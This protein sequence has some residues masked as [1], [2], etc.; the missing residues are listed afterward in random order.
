[1]YDD[2]AYSLLVEIVVKK[3]NLDPNVRLNLSFNLPS[4]DS[5]LDITNEVD[6]NLFVDCASNSIDGIPHLYVGQPK[7]RSKDNTQSSGYSSS[8]VAPKIC[9]RYGRKLERV[10]GVIISCTP[11]VLGDLTVTLKD[12][13]GTMGKSL[14]RMRVTQGLSTSKLF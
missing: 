7:N 10:V 4:L 5:Q 1:M 9:R 2:M 3:F 12:P 14:K 13:P 6:V 8:G 11:N